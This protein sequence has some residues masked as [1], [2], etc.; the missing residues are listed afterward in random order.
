MKIIKNI[1]LVTFF[2]FALFFGA[3]W[4][5]SS[6]VLHLNITPCNQEH[7]VFCG[8]PSEQGIEFQEISYATQDGFTLPAWYMPS[9]ESLKT[10]LLVH[11]RGAS[12][13]EGMRYAKPLLDN[14][15]NVLAID[16]R[17]PRQQPDIISSMS[18][19]ERKD[20]YGA[21]DYLQQHT[22]SQSIG[23]MGFSMGAA[24]SIIAMAQDKRINAGIFNSGFANSTDVLAENAATMYG[25]P[26]NPLMPAVMKLVEMRGDINS[27]MINPESYIG[28]IAPRPVYIMHGNADKTVGY[29]HGQRLFSAANEP[30]QFWTAE[31]GEHTRLWQAD[32][33]QAENLVVSFF[34]KEL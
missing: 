29:H 14:G 13:H 22:Q 25:L 15:F 8:D 11:G 24:T 23:I 28:A 4:Y 20:V 9:K 7:Y 10:V 33:A 34:Q 18:Y 16:M 30:K 31:G 26:R 6:T 27:E 19:H 2:G 5:F 17:H 21:L 1:S 3:A 12:R 32:R